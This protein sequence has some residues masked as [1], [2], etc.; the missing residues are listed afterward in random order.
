[1][2]SISLGPFALARHRD[3]PATNAAGATIPARD[4]DCTDVSDRRGGPA[5][6][7]SA[8]SRRVAAL[9]IATPAIP[10]A[11]NADAV[12]ILR[13]QS[14]HDVRRASAASA[15]PSVYACQPKSFH[16]AKSDNPAHA[17]LDSTKG[18]CHGG[19]QSCPHTVPRI[20]RAFVVE[21]RDLEVRALR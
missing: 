12:R 20:Q 21:R 3:V 11:A 14:V 19:R 8:V 6:I 13:Q 2:E 15:A 16:A 7:S 10:I 18:V 4:T 5:A 17:D 1:M 9:P